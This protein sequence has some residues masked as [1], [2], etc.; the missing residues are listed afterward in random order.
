MIQSS[1]SDKELDTL[2]RSALQERVAEAKPP[3]SSLHRLFMAVNL[4]RYR[5]TINLN[6]LPS[7][8]RQHAIQHASLSLAI[9][10]IRNPLMAVAR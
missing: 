10:T 4:L 5:R 3:R 8:S 6:Y 7:S 1:F 9:F 2:I